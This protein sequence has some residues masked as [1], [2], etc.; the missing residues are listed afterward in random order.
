MDEFNLLTFDVGGSHITAG[1]H[2]PSTLELKDVAI[3]STLGFSAAQ[4]FFD[5]LGT[6]KEKLLGT[7]R[8]EGASLAIPS[9]FDYQ[10]GVSWMQHKYPE[11]YGIDIR[12]NAAE[13]F[14]CATGKIAFLNDAD[15]FL[16]GE[17]HFGAG[18]N[19]H[20]TIGITLGTGI[21]SG[22]GVE[23]KIVT[24]GNDVPKDGEIWNLPYDG[25][26]VEDAIS[27]RSLQNAYKKK[28]GEKIEVREIAERAKSDQVAQEV[29]AEFGRNIGRVL[30][31]LSKLFS[32]DCVVFGGAITRSS[33]LFFPFIREQM[34]ANAIELR[35]AQIAD[36]AALYG[37]AVNW[38][39]NTHKD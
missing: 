33:Q 25:G 3:A 11:L 7:V 34:G 2:N 23:G 28:T 10:K 35:E 6:L 32:P 12:E 37:A 19:T 20:R 9:P 36:H 38:K 22:F 15:S 39:Q 8:V 29:F 4:D 14:Q 16:L 27:T 18:K 26:I 5:A 13:L 21:G 30:L 17:L 31:D 1:T 24:T